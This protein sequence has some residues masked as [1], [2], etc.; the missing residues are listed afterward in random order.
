M[1]DGQLAQEELDGQWYRKLEVSD[2]QRTR[3]SLRWMGWPL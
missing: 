3:L 2:Q 1:P